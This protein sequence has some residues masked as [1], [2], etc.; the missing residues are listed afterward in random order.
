MFLAAD[1]DIWLEM[2]REGLSAETVKAHPM[3]RRRY[4]ELTAQMCA[5]LSELESLLRKRQSRSLDWMVVFAALIDHRWRVANPNS[6][7]IP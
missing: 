6:L 5:Q 4:L 1:D 2:N 3:L 7:G